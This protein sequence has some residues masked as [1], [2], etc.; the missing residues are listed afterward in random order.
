MKVTI[1]SSLGGDLVDNGVEASDAA[2]EL[3]N[4]LVRWDL[5]HLN[6][7]YG[8]VRIVAGQIYI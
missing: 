1:E 2:I 5:F 3:V 8:D 6:S 4:L 7:C